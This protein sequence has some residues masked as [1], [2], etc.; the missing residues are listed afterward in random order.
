M[1]KSVDSSTQDMESGRAAPQK[2]TKLRIDTDS[3]GFRR[4]WARKQERRN[5]VEIRAS[6]RRHAWAEQGYGR[7]AVH[8]QD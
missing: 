6:T 2:I 1:S 8:E 7:W 4:V 3:L 5:T